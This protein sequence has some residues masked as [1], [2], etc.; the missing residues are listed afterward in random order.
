MDIRIAPKL[1]IHNKEKLQKVSECACY[2]CYKV[3]SPSEIKEWVDVA[4]DTALC[5]YCGIDAVL[6]IYEEGEKDL[7]FLT[8]I[9]EYW[10]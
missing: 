6:P 9:H 4:D 2:Y 1:A 7:E 3:F 5:P 8:K 10:F